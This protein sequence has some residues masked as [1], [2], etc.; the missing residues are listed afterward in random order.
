MRI[1]RTLNYVHGR[2]HIYWRSHA[3]VWP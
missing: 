3:A 2:I 1:T